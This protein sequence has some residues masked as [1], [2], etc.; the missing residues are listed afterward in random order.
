MGPSITLSSVVS[1]P[2]HGLLAQSVK[3]HCPRAT[4]NADGFGIAWYVPDV[5]PIPAI[6]K[7][8]TPAWSNQNLKQISRVTKSHCILAHVRAAS[9]GAVTQTNCHP[10]SY[11]NLSFMHNGTIAYFA[12]IKRKMMAA[13]S[14][15]SF[16][17]IQGS[18]DS[19]LMFAMFITN[20]EKLLGVS[21]KPSAPDLPYEA[22]DNTRLLAEAMKQTIL[23]VHRFVLDYEEEA[24]T[25][26]TSV[27][28]NDHVEA[29]ATG[30][31]G[32]EDGDGASL[33]VTKM[34]SR[35][36]L[37]VTDGTS[38]IVS[39]YTTGTVD[40]AHTLYWSRGTRLEVSGKECRVVH[41]N[42]QG[43]RAPPL[44]PE[45]VLDG[46]DNESMVIVSSEPLDEKYECSEV[47][48]N[49]IVVSGPN[50]FSLQPVH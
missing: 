22:E 2:S 11:R 10:F 1:E 16:D 6:Y 19:E 27:H 29:T 12:I 48:P 3:A 32:E 18:T 8:I 31:D 26:D 13:V 21:A 25:S 9:T 35:V 36:N 37:C 38:V 17:M 40:S 7:E 46:K 33:P 14:Q 50:H 47:P 41:Q 24:G 34:V 42:E 4:L 43:Q 5:S 23:Q 30:Q 39:R 20:Y 44:S 28:A 45:H 49:H 15:R